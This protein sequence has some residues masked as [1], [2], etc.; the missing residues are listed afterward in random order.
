MGRWCA[1]SVALAE[2]KT[3]R[4]LT[5]VSFSLCP[6]CSDAREAVVEEEEGRGGEVMANELIPS[7]MYMPTFSLVLLSF[8]SQFNLAVV[9]FSSNF[10][11]V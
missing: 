6:L 5:R 9:Y 1:A 2:V 7:E 3:A 8:S 11:S 10:S 4:E